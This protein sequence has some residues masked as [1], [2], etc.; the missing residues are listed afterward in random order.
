MDKKAFKRLKLGQ[1]YEVIKE[2]G[3]HTASRIYMSY[4]IHLF[5]YDGYY[6][7]IWYR[8]SLNQIA[9]IEVV[10]DDRIL[11]QYMDNLDLGEGGVG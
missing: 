6:V 5:A 10:N 11:E 9:Y 2:H 1:R 4:Q 3:T 8:L 7:E